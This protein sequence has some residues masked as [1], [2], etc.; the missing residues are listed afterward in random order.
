[1]ILFSGDLVVSKHYLFPKHWHHHNA[2]KHDFIVLNRKHVT[3]GT[4][5]VSITKTAVFVC[6]SWRMQFPTSTLDF[7]NGAN[8]SKSS[9]FLDVQKLKAHK[10]ETEHL[11]CTRLSLPVIGRKFFS[12][13][14]FCSL[15]EAQTCLN[16]LWQKIFF[17]FCASSRLQL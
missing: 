13:S 7:Q 4:T 12:F 2:V 1:M 14:L 8:I 5:V 16:M 9:T 6:I 3:L 11:Y 15:N 10:S 17:H